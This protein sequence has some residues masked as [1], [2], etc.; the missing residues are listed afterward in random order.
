MTSFSLST[1]TME[2]S[3]DHRSNSYVTSS[4]SY[5]TSSCPL[6]IKAIRLIML[7]LVFKNGIIELT[8]QAL[9]NSII[10]D[11]VLGNSKVKAVPAMVSKI[12]HAHLDKPHFLLNFGSDLSLASSTIWLKL[13]G[14]ILSTQLTNSPNTHPTQDNLMRKQSSI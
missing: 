2:S 1:L 7:E 13:R 5:V 8:Q 11:V 14:Q 12:L 3:W 4:T 6:K 9:I 10:S